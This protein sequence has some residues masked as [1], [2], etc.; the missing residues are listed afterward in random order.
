[1]EKIQFNNT[2]LQVSELCL[3]TANFG[4]IRSAEESFAQMDLFA[5]LGGNFIDTALV[6]GDWGCDERGR[7]EKVIGQW[8][9]DRKKRQ[10]VIISTKGCHPPFEDMSIPRV[11][12][13]EI[14]DDIALSLENLRTGYIDLYFL[15]RD[16]PLVPVAEI[17]ETLEE[18]VKKG[19][20]RYYG[21]S[22]WTLER[23]K[24]AA[25]YAKAHGLQGFS[26]N[27]IMMALADV[28]MSSIEW[29]KMLILD[30]DF[31]DYHKESGLNLMAFQCIAGGYFSKKI[32][33][34]EIG[35][36]QK[37]MYDCA[38]NDAIAAKMA[39]FAKEGYEPMDFM[40]RYVTK[41]A[42]PAIPIA[43]CS[44][45][46]QLRDLTR[47]VEKQV[48]DEMLDELISLKKVQKYNR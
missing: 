18:Q 8:L 6:Y 11:S 3:G 21:C 43:S 12:A 26:C 41:A 22:N 29:T 14:R 38:A 30:E 46:G 45:A 7:S 27:Q 17:L 16:N 15:H 5:E 32:A 13:A 37:A 36:G 24:E 4:T 48:P 20:L 44:T 47:S 1:M 40:L 19:N 34:K 9:S 39:D 23:V 10:D 25:A 28:D 2:N 35:D 42:F 33:G 31:Y